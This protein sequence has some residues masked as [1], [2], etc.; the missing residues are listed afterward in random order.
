[1]N[2][3]GLRVIQPGP[4]TSVQ[5][6][7]RRGVLHLGL[8][9]A[10]PLDGESFAWANRLCGNPA[11][12][13]ALEIALGGLVLEALA[14]LLATLTG[15]AAPLAVNGQPAPPWQGLRLAAGDRLSLGPTPRGG[16]LYLAVRGG[17]AVATPFGS[18][19][20]VAREGLG[21]IAGRPLARGDLLPVNPLPGPARRFALPAPLRPAYPEGGDD[22]CALRVIP[23]GQPG[24]LPRHLRRRFFDTVYHLSRQCD[25]MGYRLAG[26]A[27]DVPPLA[28]LSEAVVPGTIQLPPDGQPIVLMRDHQTLGGYPRLGTLLSLDLDRLARLAPGDALRFVPITPGAAQ[29]A[30]RAA[31]RRYLA[32]CPVALDGEPL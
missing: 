11:N 25:R 6:L 12:A 15:P 28:L 1:M 4:L 17:F 7:G 19:A 30:L 5:D 14:P 21:G 23:A 26:A 31:R 9:S 3:P 24:D 32:S 2:T 18:A 29:R 27:L 22:I 8:T 20:T 13:P 10:G 16:P